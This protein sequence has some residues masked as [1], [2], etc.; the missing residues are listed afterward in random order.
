M[1][2]LRQTIQAADAQSRSANAGGREIHVGTGEFNG[3]SECVI[4]I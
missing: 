1:L 2:P 4:G 3:K